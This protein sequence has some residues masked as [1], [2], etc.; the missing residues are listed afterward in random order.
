MEEPRVSRA[1]RARALFP[2][3]RR[4]HAHAPPPR[5]RDDWGLRHFLHPKLLKKAREV[6][7]QLE[8][9]MK[10]QKM[11]IISAGTD[12]DV[13]RYVAR[14]PA[15]PPSSLVAA[16]R[17]ERTRLQRL[18]HR[19]LA[20]RAAFALSYAHLSP[21]AA[22]AFRLFGLNPGPDLAGSTVAMLLPSSGTSRGR[23]SERRLG[24]CSPSRDGATRGRL[25]LHGDHSIRPR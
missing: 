16:L 7:V 15:R 9:I 4:A 6:R 14:S 13:I 17:D 22:R 23:R 25:I 21:D 12:F 18:R 2:S 3:P 11:D 10:F 1:K 5:Y 19:E 8:D 20:V 24:R